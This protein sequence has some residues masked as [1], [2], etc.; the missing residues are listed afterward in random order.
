MFTL[1]ASVVF[2]NRIV[3]K[4]AMASYEFYH[5]DDCEYGIHGWRDIV[6]YNHME[7]EHGNFLANMVIHKVS[8]KHF[9]LM[10]VHPKRDFV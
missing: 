2:M 10:A 1:V 9:I 4:V 5:S 3:H 8:I 7:H 6:L